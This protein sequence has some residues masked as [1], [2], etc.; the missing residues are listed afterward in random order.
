MEKLSGK[1]NLEKENGWELEYE[2]KWNWN[3]AGWWKNEIKVEN[4]TER[5]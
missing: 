5:E 3:N 1:E 4:F 2:Q